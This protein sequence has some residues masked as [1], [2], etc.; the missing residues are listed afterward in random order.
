MVVSGAR[1]RY[2][3]ARGT[4]VTFVRNFTDIDDKMIR[5]AADEN[6]TVAALADREIAAFTADVARLGCLPPN[7]EP[8]AT[9]HIPHMIALVER[10]VAKGHAYAVPGGSVYFRVRSSPGYGK[11][12][13]RRLED[14]EASEEND[15]AK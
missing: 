6:I 15:P 4:T 2:L 8:R 12:S 9:A 11:L 1:G 10:L 13:H 3:R 14:M 5:R 7:E